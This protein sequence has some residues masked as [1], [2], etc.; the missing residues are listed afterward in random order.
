MKFGSEL[1][2]AVVDLQVAASEAVAD[3]GEEDLE[4][5]LFRA[6]ISPY[7]L[8]T[9]INIATARLKVA[10]AFFAVEQKS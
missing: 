8:L 2:K 10:R 9:E 6:D 7:V 5:F 3:I 4:K 1:M